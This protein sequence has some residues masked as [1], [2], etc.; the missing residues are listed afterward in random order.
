MRIGWMRFVVGTCDD[1]DDACSSLLLSNE[2]SWSK[3]N[4][5]KRIYRNFPRAHFQQQQKQHHSSQIRQQ[6]NRRGLTTKKKEKNHSLAQFLYHFF[7]WFITIFDSTSSK[8]PFRI[9]RTVNFSRNP[10]RTRHGHCAGLWTAFS[11]PKLG[12]LKSIVYTRR[13]RSFI[14]LSVGCFGFVYFFFFWWKL[15]LGKTLW[16]FRRLWSDRNGNDKH[17]VGQTMGLRERER[18]E[19]SSR[20]KE[21]PNRKITFNSIILFRF[22]QSQPPWLQRNPTNKH[23]NKHEHGRST[24]VGLIELLLPEIDDAEPVGG[25]WGSNQSLRGDFS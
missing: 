25:C 5:P 3:Q 13:C 21:W 16:H 11:W 2:Q 20:T 6:Q 4:P 1:D 19:T 9:G 10:Q 7:V 14:W 24:A 12:K 8:W 23:E 15:I 17:T 18:E 22:L